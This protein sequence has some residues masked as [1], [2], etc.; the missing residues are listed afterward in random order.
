M[1]DAVFYAGQKDFRLF[2]NQRFLT[3]AV[4]AI[5]LFVAAKFFSERAMA[6]VSYVAGHL[7]TL[8]ALGLELGSWVQQSVAPGDQFQTITVSIS[9]LMAFYALMLI[10]LGVATKTSVNRVL[11]LVLM[12]LVVVKLYLSDVWELGYLFKIVAFVG[13]GVLLLTV[14]YLYSRFRP[15]IEKLWK[16]DPS[17]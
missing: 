7:V 17:A 13:L 15:V 12:A 11:G 2:V 8:M 16:D 1:V 5:G 3:F 14:S 10:T 6:L 9:I 4:T